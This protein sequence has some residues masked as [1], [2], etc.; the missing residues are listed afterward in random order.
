MKR[1]KA[2]NFRLENTVKRAGRA[3]SWTNPDKATVI[4]HAKLVASSTF[5]LALPL[6]L[7]RSFYGSTDW[8]V[9]LL[10]PLAWMLFSGIRKPLLATLQARSLLESRPGSPASVFSTGEVKATAYSVLFVV[11]TV[12]ILALQALGAGPWMLLTMLV[13]CVTSS[14]LVIWA[15]SWLTHYWNEP[16]ATSRGILLGSGLSAALFLPVV[17][18]LDSTLPSNECRSPGLWIWEWLR[19]VNPFGSTAEGGWVT[20]ILE[21]LLLLECTKRKLIELMGERAVLVQVLYSLSF[22]TVTF[23]VAQAG[24]AMTCFGQDMKRRW[25]VDRKG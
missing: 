10:L 9:L 1:P 20:G 5:L 6:F 25:Q 18:V 2:V 3:S 24:A 4:S 16:F 19:F 15:P 17:M 7:W 14:V 12:P 22:A 13:L 23:V 11:V 21:P 8:A